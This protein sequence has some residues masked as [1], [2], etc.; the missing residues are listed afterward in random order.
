[1]VS[2]YERCLVASLG[3]RPTAKA[4]APG[5]KSGERL[6]SPSQRPAKKTE[7]RFSKDVAEDTVGD[8]ADVHGQLRRCLETNA[9]RRS[10]PR[11]DARD[12]AAPLRPLATGWP[13]ALWATRTPIVVPAAVGKVLAGR[14]PPPVSAL[15]ES[16]FRPNH[17]T[18]CNRKNLVT[19][20]KMGSGPD[21]AVYQAQGGHSGL[22]L[23]SALR[24]T[25]CPLKTINDVKPK[26]LVGW[27]AQS[28]P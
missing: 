11:S 24:L 25:V 20:L 12:D 14:T 7:S 1:M 28:V 19:S 16:A 5:Q 27:E 17:Q 2:M 9:A 18:M 21:R 4:Y 8:R 10:A 26:R 3:L 13:R 15:R 6:G 22:R 23:V